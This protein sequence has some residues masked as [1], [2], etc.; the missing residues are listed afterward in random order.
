MNTGEKVLQYLAG[1]QLKPEGV[2]KW[3]CNSPLRPGANSHSFTLKIESDGERGVW[4][5]HSGGEGGS[6]YNLCDRL[7]IEYERKAAGGRKPVD[8]SKRAYK[9]LAEYAQLK[10]VPE[11]AFLN[12]KWKPQPVTY[13][14][15]PALE[16]PTQGGTRYRFIDGGLP[17]FKSQQGYKA[18]WYGLKPAAVYAK[19]HGLPLVLCNGE[20]SVVVA[21]HFR[22]PACAITGGEQPTLPDALLQEL[23]ATWTGAVLLAMDCDE[24]GRKAAAGKAKILQAAGF[25][26]AVVDLGMDDK[27]DLADFCKL[28][29]DSAL[30]TL[31][32]LGQDASQSHEKGTNQGAVPELAQLLK[33]LTNAR[34]AND[35]NGKENVPKLLDQIQTEVDKSRLAHMG[36]AIAPLSQLVKVRHARLD[37]ARKN[38]S[39][40]QGLRSGIIKL[41]ELIGGFVPGRVCTFIG[42]TGM[43]KSTVVS[44]IAANFAAQAP[45]IIIPTESMAGDYLDKLAAYK[46]NV[47][48]DLIETGT[49]ADQQYH[50]VLAMYNWLEE[51]QVDMLDTLNPSSSS[52]GSAIREGIKTRGYQ[53]VLIDSLN[54]LSSLIHDD[55]Y[56]KTSEAADFQQELLRLG[57]VVISTAQVGRNLKDRKNKIPKLGDALGSGRIEQ[58]ADVMIALYNHQ[59]YVDQGDAELNPKFP[60]GSMFVR[61]LKH[62]WRGTAGGKSTYLAFKGGVGVYD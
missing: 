53:W 21:L 5:D 32:A 46:A 11:Q 36:Q 6:L 52:I 58:N 26:V 10:G 8:N 31:L 56:G 7:G 47:P 42:D 27:G 59:Y 38:P 45:G 15:R 9:N 57:L 37:A 61:C 51:K 60:P 24:T 13:D 1:Y 48:Y 34:R 44:A 54:N 22:I 12:A 19:E 3:R 35:L 62:R 41:D 39:P 23:K 33:E 16:F 49:L 43:G 20:P 55:I 2:G 30:D 17:A 40:V 25:T 50:T 4:D 28:Y 18:C 14:K 29:T